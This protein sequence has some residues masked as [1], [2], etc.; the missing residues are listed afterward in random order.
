MGFRQDRAAVERVKVRVMTL[1][2]LSVEPALVKVDVEGADYRVIAGSS[3]VLLRFRPLVLV[4]LPRQAI[5]AVL[6]ELGYVPFAYEEPRRLI[7]GE[8]GEL[9]TYFLLPEHRAQLDQVIN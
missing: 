2:E 5:V 3:Q 7:E 9:N 6:T 4:E 8:R 1:D